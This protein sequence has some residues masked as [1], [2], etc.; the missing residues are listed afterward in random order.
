MALGQYLFCPVSLVQDACMFL[1]L[2]VHSFHFER[3][4]LCILHLHFIKFKT[5]SCSST[6]GGGNEF[7]FLTASFNI[8]FKV[9]SHL[10]YASL[11]HPSVALSTDGERWQFGNFESHSSPDPNWERR[12]FAGN[13]ISQ[14]EERKHG[15]TPV[16]GRSS[17]K[18]AHTLN[19]CVKPEHSFS[20][21]GSIHRLKRKLHTEHSIAQML[22]VP[23][24]WLVIAPV[25]CN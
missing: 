23:C 5:I 3:K 16:G 6:H 24:S 4:V 14:C 2:C 7:V 17:K 11:Q 10:C 8:S 21:I 19:R 25:M 18:S 1:L 15:A 22:L 9:T 13:L 12:I 20:S